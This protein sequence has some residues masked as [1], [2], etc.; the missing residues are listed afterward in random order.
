ML[1]LDLARAL[2]PG[3]GADFGP[4][5]AAAPVPESGSGM[6]PG[7]GPATEIEVEI[8]IGLALEL[9]RLCAR[10]AARRRGRCRRM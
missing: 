6:K 7:T 2:Q 8:G 3:V 9:L 5:F 4:E 10:R 1:M